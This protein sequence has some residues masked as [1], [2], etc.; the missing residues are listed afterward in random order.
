MIHL[1]HWEQLPQAHWMLAA[2]PMEAE[3]PSEK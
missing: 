2:M 1:E 3:H